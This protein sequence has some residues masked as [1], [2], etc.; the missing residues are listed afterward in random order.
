MAQRRILRWS[1]WA[2][3]AIV[4]LTTAAVLSSS[5]WLGPLAA[6]QASAVLG[7]PVEIERLH[8]RLGSPVAVIAEGVVIGNPLGFLPGEEPFLRIPR[9]TV[10][11]DAGAYLRRQAIVIPLIELDRAVTRAVSTADGRTNYSFKFD[12]NRTRDASIPEIGAMRIIDGRARV[13]LAGLRADF[14]VALSSVDAAGQE[15]RTI[16]AEA[17]GT[18]A[19]QSLDATF[20]ANALPS[21]R[22]PTADWPVEL[23]VTNGPTRA[24]LR[25]TLQVSPTPRAASLDLQLAGPDMALLRPLTGIPLLPTPPYDLGG[26]LDY[27]EGRFHFTGVAGRVGRSDVEGTLTVIQR[28]ERPELT[29]E[30]R[31]RSVDLH[32]IAGLLGGEPGPPGTPGQ[33]PQQQKRA[34]QV[35]EQARANPRLLPDKPLNLPKLRGLDA[36]LVYHAERI[37]GRSMPLDDLTLRMDVVDGALALRP[38]S[39]GVGA[40]RIVGDILVTPAADEA[41]ETRAEVRFERL[42]LARLMQATGRHQGTGALSGMARVEGTGRSIA[43]I[44]GHGDG[45]LALSMTD[46]TLSKLLVDLTGLRLGSALLTSLGGEARTRIECF[47]ADLAL[48]RGTLSTRALLLETED[49]VTEGQG[50]LDLE[51][52]HVEMRLR[53]ASKHLAVGVVPVPLLINGT[54]KA[55]S[56]APDRAEGANGGIASA[57]AALPTIQFGIGDDQRCEGLVRRAR[58]GAATGNDAGQGGAITSGGRR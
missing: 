7:R 25:G 52:E 28:P 23:H 58:R 12:A 26:K 49:A 18:Y 47:V 24:S 2:G 15:Q 45:A 51:H 57:L 11:L 1:L 53:T 38:L 17:R 8:L 32:D 27:T 16:K 34:A 42:D 39:F 21:L 50:L 29:A 14:E 10:W 48:R 44:L 40:G 20:L 4:G 31:S 3:L 43:D 56:A 55:P 22:D 6:R 30:L 19:D 36:H 41:V 35:R 37:Q 5:L 13:S 33:T 9:L 46:G 54:L